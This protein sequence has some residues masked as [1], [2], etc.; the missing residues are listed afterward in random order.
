MDYKDRLYYWQIEEKY[1]VKFPMLKNQLKGKGQ[2]GITSAQKRWLWANGVNVTGIK[3]KGSACA[4]SDFVKRLKENKNENKGLYQVIYKIN[5]KWYGSKHLYKTESEAEYE[6]AKNVPP[7]YDAKIILYTSS[8]W[9]TV[10]GKCFTR[11]FYALQTG[12]D[13]RLF[14][15]R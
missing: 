4:I 12:E 6:A 15:R 5:D 8:Y 9:Q 14:V 10:S 7:K 2:D 3:Y 11:R 13:C 1:N